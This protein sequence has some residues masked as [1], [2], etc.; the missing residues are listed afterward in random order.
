MCILITSGVV[1][2]KPY[3]HRS[4]EELVK[5]RPGA[6]PESLAFPTSIQGRLKLFV[7]GDR[8]TL[9]QA[10]FWVSES[11]PKL[12]V[13]TL[14][15]MVSYLGVCKYGYNHPQGIEWLRAE[16]RRKPGRG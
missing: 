7:L 8:S 12:T 16:R 10:G 14:V 1:L 3:V 13:I 9:K 2:L 15:Y 4:P 5:C 6:G 11:C